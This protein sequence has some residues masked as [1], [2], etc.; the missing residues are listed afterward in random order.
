MNTFSDANDHFASP[1]RLFTSCASARDYCIGSVCEKCVYISFW[2][3]GINVSRLGEYRR[4][5]LFIMAQRCRMKECRMMSLGL[6]L[7]QVKGTMDQT[8]S[9]RR[10]R[11]GEQETCECTKPISA[12]FAP[13]KRISNEYDIRNEC[14]LK[15]W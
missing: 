1:P 7:H 9:P 6:K 8:F 5:S 10:A 3:V 14:Q 4:F 2:R 11:R 13:H 12:C 15:M